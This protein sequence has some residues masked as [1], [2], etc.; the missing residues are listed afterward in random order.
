MIILT[1]EAINDSDTDEKFDIILNLLMECLDILNT[2]KPLN[3]FD[4]NKQMSV[5]GLDL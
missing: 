2:Q 1:T 3:K 5:N 4:T